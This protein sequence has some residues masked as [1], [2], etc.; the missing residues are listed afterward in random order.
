MLKE[1]EKKHPLPIK[2]KK[3]H[4]KKEKPLQSNKK[5]VIRAVNKGGEIVIQDFLDYHQEAMTTWIQS[6]LKW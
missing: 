3:K 1:C 2:V 5:I 6:T 4:W